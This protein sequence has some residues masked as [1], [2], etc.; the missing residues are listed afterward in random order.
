MSKENA[1]DW[2]TNYNKVPVA[3]LSAAMP[4]FNWPAYLEASGF[5]GL[6][7]VVFFAVWL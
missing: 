2:A 1:R 6:D 4:N 7:A 3:E 5:A